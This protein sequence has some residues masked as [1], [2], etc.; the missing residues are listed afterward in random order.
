MGQ[1]FFDIQYTCFRSN[2]LG[3][4]FQIFD[5]GDGSAKGKNSDR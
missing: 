5:G 3:T 2:M 4:N 1:D